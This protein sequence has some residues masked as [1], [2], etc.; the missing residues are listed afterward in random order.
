MGAILFYHGARN[1]LYNKSNFELLCT[2]CAQETAVIPVAVG[3][4]EDGVINS[5]QPI[6]SKW[7]PALEVNGLVAQPGEYDRRYRQ[8][9]FGI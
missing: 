5:Q 7:H 9:F 2:V 6:E 1:L 8:T 3:E 4:T